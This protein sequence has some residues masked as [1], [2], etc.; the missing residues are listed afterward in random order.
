M[1]AYARESGSDAAAPNAATPNP[2][3]PNPVDL[4]RFDVLNER[5]WVIPHPSVA[6][7][8]VD[9]LGGVRS[10]LAD[11][12]IGFFGISSNLFEY[13]LTQANLGKP[14]TVNGQVG[15]WNNAY[16]YLSFTYD[17]GRFG[18]QG[19]Q[20]IFTGYV[21]PDSLPQLNIPDVARIGDVS[22]NQLLAGGKIDLQV[23]YS[24]SADYFVGTEVGGSL[25][26]GVLGP[27]AIIPYEVGLSF[28]P[29]AT[30]LVWI[31]GDLGDGFYDRAGVQ[32][33]LP[34]GGGQVEARINPG[35]GLK[36]AP[37]GTDVLFINE[38]GYQ[39]PPAAG[40]ASTWIRIGGIYNTT[41]YRSFLSG[42]EVQNWALYVLPDRQ[43]TSIDPAQPIRGLYIGG[44]AMYAPPGQNLFTQ[45]YE[46]RTYYFGA[47]DAR[48][49]DFASVVVSYEMYSRE[50][51]EVLAP[52]P[53][54]AFAQ[55]VTAI[56]SY[57]FHVRDG[58]YVQPGIG[59]TS[60][61]NVSREFNNS[62]DCY[63]GLTGFF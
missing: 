28:P 38:L 56:G 2:A 37:E 16:Q 26:A 14:L 24:N 15:T 36:F 45:Y 58:F 30:P 22:Y 55:T 25:A 19:G 39:T 53:F 43:L 47:F 59:W 23:G 27:Q 61:A 13:D 18:L 8:I 50:G 35:V 6:D 17:T 33:S 57:A 60:H 40:Q 46:F 5:G 49:T 41:K 3:T 4:T 21:I 1:V 42:R 10:A 32:R 44:S 48:P 7:T 34:P 52:P 11:V 29:F 20:L 9:D 51:R 62:F 31:K 12:G 63:L 54:G